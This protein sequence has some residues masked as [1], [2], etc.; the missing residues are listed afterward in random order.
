MSRNIELQARCADLDAAA[1]TALELHAVLHSVERQHDTYFQAS[2]GRLKLRR[3][4]VAGRELPAELIGYQR[5]DAPQA[6]G[7]DYSLVTSDH[8][9]SLRAMLADALG[10]AIEV[11]KQRIVY[12]HDGVRIHLEAVKG[13][14][15]F[16]EFEAIVDAQCDDTAA[17]AKL[18]RLCA[19]FGITGAQI[20]SESYA[21]LQHR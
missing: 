1:R 17:H 7:S 20:A 9:E 19:A 8:G 15:T 5:A 21:D 18:D 13:L 14:G 3:R 10:I 4:W 11:D 6:R 12:L 2:R 16:V